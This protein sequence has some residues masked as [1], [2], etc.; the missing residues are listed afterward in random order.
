MTLLLV[1]L[2]FPIFAFLPL[3]TVAALLVQVAVSMVEHRAIG[4]Y[5]ALDP[6]VFVLT[7]LVAVVCCVWDPT[8]GIVVGTSITHRLPLLPCVCS[9]QLVL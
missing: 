4:K 2:V 8:T 6:V 5:L 3:P 1:V 9:L 7:L